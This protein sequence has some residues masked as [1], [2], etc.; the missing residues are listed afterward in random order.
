MKEQMPPLIS[1]IVPVYNVQQYLARCLDSIIDQTYTNLEIIVVDDGSTD[2]SGKICDQYAEKDNRIQV[3]HCPYGGVSIARNRGIKAAKGSYLGFI[4]SDDWI[5]PNFYECLYNSLT[6]AHA[7]IAFCSVFRHKKGECFAKYKSGKV[8]CWNRKE[9]LIH[10]L[11][12]KRLRDHVWNKLY[13]KALFDGISFPPDKLY[14][15]VLTLYKVFLK[16]NKAVYIQKPLYHYIY[17]EG[18]ISHTRKKRRERECQ[19]FE[20]LYNRNKF[21]YTYD[22]T[23]LSVSLNR[24]LQIGI[25]VIYHALRDR[26]ENRELIESQVK[27]LSEMDKRKAAWYLHAGIYLLTKY[28]ALHTILDNYFIYRF[29]HK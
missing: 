20:A 10:L 28:F 23:L 16:V 1:I 4:D 9:S 19:L 3:L 7:D 5:E 8:V 11:K 18:S 6:N 26:R 27:C 29:K 24:T 17:R 14:E 15:D 21:F 25:K 2:D 12:A 13:K 22:Q